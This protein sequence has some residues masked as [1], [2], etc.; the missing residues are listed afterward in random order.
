MHRGDAVGTTEFDNGAPQ[1]GGRKLPAHIRKTVDK[2]K[3]N[4][5][6]S[7]FHRNAET[8]TVI[9]HPGDD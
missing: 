8:Y 9:Y 1:T 3:S 4:A 6:I 2:D 5:G 7:Y